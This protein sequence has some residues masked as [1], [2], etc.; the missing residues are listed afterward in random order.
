MITGPEADSS[1]SAALLLLPQT[2]D[3]DVSADTSLRGREGNSS[4]PAE[5]ARPLILQWDPSQ[6]VA[7]RSFSEP[8]VEIPCLIPWR[9]LF[10]QEHTQK[11][12]ACPYH[13]IPSGDLRKNT[14]DEIWNGEHAQELRRSLLRHKI[15]R[16]CLNHSAGCPVIMKARNDGHKP[17][18]TDEIEMGANDFWFLGDG[19]FQLE[20][21]S[22][23]I[24]WTSAKAQFRI[25]AT[26]KQGLRLEVLCAHPGLKE[27]PLRGRIECGGDVLGYFSIEDITWISLNF[28]LLGRTGEIELDIVMEKPWVPKSIIE[29]N[30]DTRSLGFGV[31]RIWSW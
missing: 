29:D 15:T 21:I 24:R 8:G 22:D 30:G 3:T 9:Y 19:W 28:S 31:R 5:E 13:V 2:L 23:A 26:N 10:I 4:P 25:D 16:F 12:I 6:D 20:H 14:L 1:I 17:P 27:E 7:V 11:T 18:A